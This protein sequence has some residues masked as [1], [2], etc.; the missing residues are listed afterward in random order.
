V[1]SRAAISGTQLGNEPMFVRCAIV[2]TTLRLA[3]QRFVFGRRPINWWVIDARL[4]R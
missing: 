2:F 4:V 1:C 3:M